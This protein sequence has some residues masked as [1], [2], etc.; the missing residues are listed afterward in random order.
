MKAKF[1]S[2][3]LSLLIISFFLLLLNT[4]CGN[5][6][7]VKR[8]T[9]A[10]GCNTANSFEKM[11]YNGLEAKKAGD[12]D[13]AIVI[14][15]KLAT[16]I[17]IDNNGDDVEQLA[18]VYNQLGVSYFRRGNIDSS[19]VWFKEGL[20]INIKYKG[21]QS[22]EVANNYKFF[23]LAYIE[24]KNYDKSL[25]YLKKALKIQLKNSATEKFDLSDTYKLISFVNHKKGNSKEARKYLQ[26][27]Q[28][29]HG[30]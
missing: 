18:L 10:K 4:G 3:G 17:I 2:R 5:N 8:E 1:K 19:I 15:S 13:K 30:K 14:F 7:Q 12:Y 24:K 9:N 27:S 6:S 11:Y 23:A 22:I 21:K 20:K 25:F 29:L 16:A 28:E 26:K